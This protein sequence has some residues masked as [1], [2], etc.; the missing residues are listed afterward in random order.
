MYLP[1]IDHLLEERNT[2]PSTTYRVYLLKL[3]VICQI[4]NN[5]SA[6][7]SVGKLNVEQQK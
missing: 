1:F 6:K 5:F 2:D 3:K 4:F 7:F